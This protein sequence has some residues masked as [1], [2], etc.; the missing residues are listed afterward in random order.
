MTPF[1]QQGYERLTALHHRLK[2]RYPDIGLSLGYVGN[3]D[4]WSDDRA[5]KFFTKVMKPFGTRT[6]AHEQFSWGYASSTQL[7]LLADRAEAGLEAWIKEHVL[8]EAANRW[9]SFEIKGRNIR[10]R[11]RE[12]EAKGWQYG[13]DGQDRCEVAVL[14]KTLAEVREFLGPGYEVTEVAY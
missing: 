12:F 14:A 1:D 11:R 4:N 13:S 10:Y 9:R 6:Y 7:S 2:E 5:W 8:P 3:C